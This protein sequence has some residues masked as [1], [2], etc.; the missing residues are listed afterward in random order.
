MFK[1]VTLSVG[2]V[3]VAVAMFE[4]SAEACGRCRR[5]CCDCGSQGGR[6]GGSTATSGSGSFQP[7]SGGSGSGTPTPVSVKPDGESAKGVKGTATP[8]LAEMQ[9]KMDLL[10]SR[11]GIVDDTSDPES[12]L[13]ASITGMILRDLAVTVRD[14][15]KGKLKDKIN[16]KPGAAGPSNDALVKQI[17]TMMDQ[18][19]APLSAKV[20]AA[21]AKVDKLDRELA[22][23][24]TEAVKSDAD[25]KKA[26]KEAVK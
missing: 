12:A 21:S 5:N 26:L 23:R 13:L 25:L 1:S 19:L 6:G 10:H 11:L 3:L 24:I 17:G 2:I 15:L 16:I 20:D 9:K 14:D 7:P 18:K 22:K 8:E 4:S